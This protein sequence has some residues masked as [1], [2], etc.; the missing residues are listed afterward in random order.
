VARGG[1]RGRVSVHDA[2]D[3]H[4]LG[5]GEGEGVEVR[6]GGVGEARWRD[7]AR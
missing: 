3:Q 2:A 4:V 6:V 5:E 7:E 1:R